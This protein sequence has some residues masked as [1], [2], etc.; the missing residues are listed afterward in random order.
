MK[1]S[2]HTHYYKP[3][4]KPSDKVLIESIEQICLDFP[5]YG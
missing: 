4:G 2:R 1:L 5:K 3:K